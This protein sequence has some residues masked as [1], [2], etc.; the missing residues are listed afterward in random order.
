MKMKERRDV[1][2]ILKAGE[3]VGDYGIHYEYN[4]KVEEVSESV[5]DMIEHKGS[6][7]FLDREKINF[8]RS[9]TDKAIADEINKRTGNGEN[10]SAVIAEIMRRA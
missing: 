9:S 4:P 5:Y 2:E 10:I 7:L 1:E 3:H 6:I 8:L